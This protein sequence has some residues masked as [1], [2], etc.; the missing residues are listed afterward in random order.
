VRI[1]GILKSVEMKKFLI[2]AGL[3]LSMCQASA[4]NV[5]TLSIK[6]MLGSAPFA[7]NTTAQSNLSQDFKITRVDYYISGIKIIH[8]GGTETAV[9]NHY[10]IAK[11]D[12]NVVD[13]LGSFTN[14][15]NIEGIK[16]SVGVD[17]PNNNADP[18]QWP[19]DHPLSFQGPSMHWGWTS[20]YR[21]I[22]LEGTTGSGFT[23]SFQM[24]ALGNVNYLEQTVM[25]P[26]VQV[27]NKKFINLDADYV[28]ALKNVDISSGPIDHGVNQTDLAVLLNFHDNVFKAG[29][30]LPAGIDANTQALD[31][32]VAPNPTNGKVYVQTASAD[33]A[34]STIVVC[35]A[36]GREVVHIQH[37][38]GAAIDLSVQP[39]GLYFVK[40]LSGNTVMATRTL[41]LD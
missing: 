39:R 22:A 17:Y 38:A 9:P 18:T 5:V 32:T 6:H 8:D 2:A 37:V 36:F 11:G 28:Q 40:L 1:F 13:D 24:H 4:Q 10:I 23:K 25:V 14:I 12:Q 26:G 41:L 20:G 19:S 29:A 34:H 27:G 7:L 35:D 31:F 21:F 3:L 30:G 16:F 33:L 15:T